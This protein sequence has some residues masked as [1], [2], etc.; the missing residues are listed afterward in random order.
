MIHR[1]F[2]DRMF[3]KIYILLIGYTGWTMGSLKAPSLCLPPL[4]QGLHIRA[5]LCFPMDAEAQNSGPY[6]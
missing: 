2:E 4:S 3:H 5:V 6:I 1:L